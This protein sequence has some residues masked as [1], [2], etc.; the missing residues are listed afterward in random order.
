MGMTLPPEPWPL[1]RLAIGALEAEVVAALNS[2]VETFD[3]VV[4]VLAHQ[5]GSAAFG[6]GQLGVGAPF[7]AGI[8]QRTIAMLGMDGA[9]PDDLRRVAALLHVTACVERIIVRC[10]GLAG[11]VPGLAPLLSGDDGVRRA[12]EL[13]VLA[14]RHRLVMARDAVLAAT[15]L[16]ASTGRATA[17]PDGGPG[18]ALLTLA[19]AAQAG[20]APERSMASAIG[21]LAS[22]LDQ[23]NLEAAY[24]GEEAMSVTVGLF[25]EMA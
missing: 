4:Q 11:L 3:R 25:T 5:V 20:R 15:T 23:I 2:A 8:N 22:L 6:P 9:S 12:S 18:P 14:T 21:R 24:I 17:P 10:A 19:A 13:E 16:V 7:A 1:R